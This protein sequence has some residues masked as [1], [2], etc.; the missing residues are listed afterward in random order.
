MIDF[1]TNLFNIIQV[2]RASMRSQHVNC[3]W[4]FTPYY[5][6][7]K[8]VRLTI[9]F[10][11]PYQINQLKRTAFAIT[12]STNS[13]IYFTAKNR[14]QMSEITRWKNVVMRLF[15]SNLLSTVKGLPKKILHYKKHFNW[16]P[17]CFVKCLLTPVFLTK[18]NSFNLYKINILFSEIF[19][20]LRLK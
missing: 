3:C 19:K 17:I 12:L 2:I 1:I 13:P 18:E 8:T 5:A 11:H 4:K 10:W 7:M 16:A 6:R 14:V 20:G 9:Q 15:R